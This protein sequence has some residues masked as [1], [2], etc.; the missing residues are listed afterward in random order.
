MYERHKT[1][2]NDAWRKY[3]DIKKANETTFK[4]NPS[5]TSNTAQNDEAKKL[6]L[7]E[8]LRTETCTHSGL[9]SEVAD[10]PWSDACRESGNE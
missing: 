4:G 10:S 8:S 9:S 5:A 1:Y 7:S 6:A 2:E 3:F